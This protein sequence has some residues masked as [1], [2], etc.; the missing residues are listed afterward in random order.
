MTESGFIVQLIEHTEQAGAIFFPFS[1]LSELLKLKNKP[2]SP[3]QGTRGRGSLG[4]TM[5]RS[6]L[7]ALG[8]LRHVPCPSPTLPTQPEPGTGSR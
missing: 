5:P 1:S 4:Q 3:K 2:L 6:S 7:D 8:N